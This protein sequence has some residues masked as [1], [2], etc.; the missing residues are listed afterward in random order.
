[1]VA[2]E[3]ARPPPHLQINTS[4]LLISCVVFELLPQTF[5][6]WLPTCKLRLVIYMVFRIEKW[7]HSRYSMDESHLFPVFLSPFISLPPFYFLPLL[8]LSLLSRSLPLSEVRQRPRLNISNGIRIGV[9]TGNCGIQRWTHTDGFLLSAL[10]VQGKT[11]SCVCVSRCT[12]RAECVYSLPVPTLTET[13][14]S[15]R[16][17]YVD[18]HTYQKGPGTKQA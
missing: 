13:W 4:P 18:I 5:G 1:M 10:K 9:G 16:H 15:Y 6:P 7:L 14:T 2:W 12:H 17:S 3:G 8:L 11:E